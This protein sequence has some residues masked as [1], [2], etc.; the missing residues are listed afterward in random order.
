MTFAGV[1]ADYFRDY[2]MQ[3]PEASQRAALQNM[4]DMG[5]VDLLDFKIDSL[6]T[7][8]KPLCLRF[9]YSLKKLFRSSEDR[10]A[11]LLQGGFAA[12]FIKAAPA[13]ARLTPFQLNIPTSLEFN[14]VMDVPKGF[15]AV[16]PENFELNLDPRFATGH[17]NVLSQQMAN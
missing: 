10:L 4:A 13:D 7:P 1:H 5:D 11:G 2:L 17:G 14:V 15:K 12:A 6:D 9:T 16:Q 8:G 3:V